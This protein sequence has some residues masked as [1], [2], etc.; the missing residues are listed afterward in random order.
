MPRVLFDISGSPF[1]KDLA[2]TTQKVYKG[3]LN[4]LAEEGFDTAQKLWSKP[5]RA[6]KAIKKLTGDG[7]AE[8]DNHTR[9]LILSA[10]FA[11][12]SEEQRKSNNAFYRYYQ[13]VLPKKDGATEKAW[14]PR[15]DY[16]SDSGSEDNSTPTM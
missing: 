6:V 16:V 5:G 7:T 15:K 4:A 1:T 11:V 12:F 8:T 9:R 2:L 14:L 3:K 10:I 13:R